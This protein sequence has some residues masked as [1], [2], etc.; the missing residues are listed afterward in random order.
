[1]TPSRPTIALAFMMAL[2]LIGCAESTGS[3][4]TSDSTLPSRVYEASQQH[5]WDTV[6]TVALTIPTWDIVK[7]DEPH[8]V[9]YIEQRFRDPSFGGESRLAIAVTPL[10]GMHTKVDVQTTAA[11]GPRG[12][13]QHSIWRFL[14]ELDQLLE[15]K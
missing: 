10:D 3:L 12:E 5:V 11:G 14:G 13:L 2:G 8:G 1:M 6:R 4:D 9:V 15:K 7:A